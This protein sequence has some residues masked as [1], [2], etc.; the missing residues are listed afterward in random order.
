M[1]NL[2]I[3][4]SEYVGNLLYSGTASSGAKYCF[5]HKSH[6]M[7]AGGK[8]LGKLRLFYCAECVAKR[9]TKKEQTA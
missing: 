5:G 2:R 9:A 3:K 7:T 4:D 1:S 6:R 8:V